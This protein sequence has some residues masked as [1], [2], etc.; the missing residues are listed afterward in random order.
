M[1]GTIAVYSQ[2]RVRLHGVSPVVRLRPQK[3]RGRGTP[4]AIFCTHYCTLTSGNPNES[5]MPKIYPSSPMCCLQYSQRVK[6]QHEITYNYHIY[7]VKF[8]RSSVRNV[9]LTGERRG[10]TKRSSWQPRAGQS[11]WRQP[12]ILRCAALSPEPTS[13]ITHTD[14]VLCRFCAVWPWQRKVVKTVQL[15]CLVWISLDT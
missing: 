9:S 7:A 13:W 10:S 3:I 8:T 6:K 11:D 5:T 12:C 14:T 2:G 4:L 1:T 15:H